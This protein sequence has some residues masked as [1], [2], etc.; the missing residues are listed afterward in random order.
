MFF[1]LSRSGKSVRL[2]VLTASLFLLGAL[3][4]HGRD[5][6]EPLPVIN[7]LLLREYKGLSF[8]PGGYAETAFVHQV[9][10]ASDWDA[11][12]INSRGG[13]TIYGS[14]A[15]ALSFTYGAFLMNGPVTVGRSPGS[16]LQ[17]IMNAVQFEYGFHA[18][19]DVGP[20]YLLAEYSRTSQH[21]MVSDD[22]EGGFS[23]VSSDL[24]KVGFAAP[25]LKLGPVDL[26]GFSRFGYAAIFD[27]WD[28]SIPQP[29]TKWAAQPSLRAHWEGEELLGVLKAGLFLELDGEIG[30]ARE[31]RFA[32]AGEII[33]NFAAKGG[34][35]L[36][37]FSRKAYPSRRGHLS[38]GSLDFYVDYYGSDN[39]EIR[40]NEPTP[41]SLLG[42]AI[43]MRLFY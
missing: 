20:L 35:R 4:A 28:S 29:R 18:A 23:E 31:A 10:K 42:Y 8:A 22:G 16:R 11:H 15:F 1:P 7:P 34:L 17:W 37:G 6:Y 26:Y 41:V 30:I 9:F 3:T 33:G 14:E 38:P 2:T 12:Q 39:S 19:Y 32:E 5:W 43:R 24:V 13:H 36:R 40:D 27:F 25:R 21:P